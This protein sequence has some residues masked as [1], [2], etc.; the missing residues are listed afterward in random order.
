MSNVKDCGSRDKEERDLRNIWN[1]KPAEIEKT[2]RTA[3]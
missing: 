3:T 2:E 1:I